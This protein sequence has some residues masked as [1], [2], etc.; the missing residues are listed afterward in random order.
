[1]QKYLM[2]YLSLESMWIACNLTIANTLNV[3][4]LLEID[5]DRQ[6]GSSLLDLETFGNNKITCHHPAAKSTLLALINNFLE[7]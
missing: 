2:Y 6:K 3:C 5:F 7:S 1:M 4:D